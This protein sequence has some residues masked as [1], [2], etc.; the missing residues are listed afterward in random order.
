MR[1]SDASEELVETQIFG[2]VEIG[3]IERQ[4]LDDWRMFGENLPYFA[5]RVCVERRV[6]RPLQPDDPCPRITPPSCKSIVFLPPF[7]LRMAFPRSDYYGGSA[8]GVVRLRPSRVAR[9]RLRTGQTIRVPVFRFSTFVSLDGGLYPG[10]AGDGPKRAVP[11]S[12]AIPAPG[13]RDGMTPAAS[14]RY[15]P[16][17]QNKHAFLPVILLGIE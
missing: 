10:D 7:A 16:K 5:D 17:H 3:L 15:D 1:C 6:L 4:R 12:D 2:D 8:L 14:N 9:L 13:S 11:A